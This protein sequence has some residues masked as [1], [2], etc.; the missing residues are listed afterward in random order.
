[1]KITAITR[2]KQ[3]D[4]F[5]A[6]QKLDWSQSE[7][8]R[9]CNI[10]AST[11]GTIINLQKRPSCK[12][13]DKI[14]NVLG[15]AGE[16]VDV[17]A[18]W[19][20]TFTGFKKSPKSIDTK[21]IDSSYL[22]TCQDPF[23]LTYEQERREIIGKTMEK[24]SERERYIIEKRFFEDRTYDS[25]SKENGVTKERIRQIESKSLK[26]LQGMLKGMAGEI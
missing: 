4:L 5:L 19:P 6:L 18:M 12:I 21:E 1:M 2:Y 3:G 15:E 9:R 20:E 13:A 26:K 14:Q 10:P 23:Q 16:F 17:L 24:L 8:A 11:I 7:L 22:L 25:L